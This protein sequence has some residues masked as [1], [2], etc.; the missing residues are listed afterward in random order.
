M[1]TKMPLMDLKVI[2]NRDNIIMDP[3]MDTMFD[4]TSYKD[5]T[6]EFHGKSIQVIVYAHRKWVEQYYIIENLNSYN[7]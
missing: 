7:I 2:V 6:N 1:H 3:L 5:A 4:Y